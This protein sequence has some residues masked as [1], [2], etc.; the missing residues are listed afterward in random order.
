LTKTE[1]LRIRVS[2][3]Q[4]RAVED[5]ARNASLDMSSWARMILTQFATASEPGNQLILATRIE[6]KL[7]V[8]QLV[9]GGP[10][11][12]GGKIIAVGAAISKP[13]REPRK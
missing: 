11:G 5:A 13:K 3:E 6:G 7:E 9:T 10:F 4:K 1:E 8:G 2:T 12:Q